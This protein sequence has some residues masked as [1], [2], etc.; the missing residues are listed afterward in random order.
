[1]VQED[2]ELLLKDLCAKL[3]YGLKGKITGAIKETR[4][5][6]NYFEVKEKIKKNESNFEI[7]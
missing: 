6:I 3:S 2:K 5:R 4:G 1:M 7:L